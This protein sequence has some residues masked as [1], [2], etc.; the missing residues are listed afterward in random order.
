MHAPRPAIFALLLASLYQVHAQIPRPRMPIPVSIYQD[1]E[2]G[3]RFQ[4]PVVWKQASRSDNYLSPSVLKLG[5]DPKVSVAF[6]PEGNLYE[7]TNLSSLTFTFLAP[8]VASK[9]A[10]QARV[11]TN[12]SM[13]STE[14]QTIHEVTYLH[15]TGGDAGMCHQQQAEV[16]ATYRAGRCYIFEKDFNTTCPFPDQGRRELTQTERTAL[17]RHLDAIMETVSFSTEEK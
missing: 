9:S 7:K 12:P 6:S 3:V 10:C 14:E 2:S 1:K 11:L 4:Y 5:E 15:G 16:Y 13:R 17:Q 8:A